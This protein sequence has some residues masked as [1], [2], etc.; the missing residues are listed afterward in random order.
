M[1]TTTATEQVFS[2][3]LDGPLTKAAFYAA[4]SE[5]GLQVFERESLAKFLFHCIADDLDDA[6]FA[7]HLEESAKELKLFGAI[8]EDRAAELTIERNERL[9]VCESAHALLLSQ[10]PVRD[11]EL[12]RELADPTS[13]IRKVLKDKFRLFKQT[14]R[15]VLGESEVRHEVEPKP[16]IKLLDTSEQPVSPCGFDDGVAAFITDLVNEYSS[17]QSIH[18]SFN[19]LHEAAAVIQEEFEEFWDEVKRKSS[20]RNPDAI[21]RELIQVAAMAMKAALFVS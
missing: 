17:A 6:K 2:F 5:D 18:G 20:D 3:A 7:S 9:A 12:C 15:E 14:G 13:P 8:A 4:S 21:R 19:S 11:S 10:L 16:A 1:A